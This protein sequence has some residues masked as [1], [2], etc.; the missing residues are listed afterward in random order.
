MKFDT[1]VMKLAAVNTQDFL[2]VPEG[3]WER[4]VSAAIGRISSILWQRMDA[5]ICLD[6]EIPLKKRDGSPVTN[7]YGEPTKVWNIFNG[8]Y[9]KINQEILILAETDKAL[10]AQLQAAVMTYEKVVKRMAAKAKDTGKTPF[11]ILDAIGPFWQQKG[12]WNPPPA[13]TVAT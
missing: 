3:V 9:Y 5:G 1:E 4:Q 8:Q 6:W 13:T 2:T 7:Q 12:F 11:D 10:A